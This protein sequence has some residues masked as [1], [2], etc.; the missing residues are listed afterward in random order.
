MNIEKLDFKKGNGLIPAIVQDYKNNEV[1]MLAY[2]NKES[3]KKT[4]ETGETWFFSRS[5]KMLWHKGE[6]S[7]NIQTIK[8]IKVDC[9]NDTVLFLVKQKGVACHTGEKSCF[10]RSIDEI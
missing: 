7:G 2:V 10:Y 1:L 3:M 4:I 9:D 5:R 6:T 8:E